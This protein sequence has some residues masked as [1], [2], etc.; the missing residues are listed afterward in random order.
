MASEKAFCVL[1]LSIDIA[2]VPR[3]NSK[4]IAES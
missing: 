4:L 2:D 1:K 3:S